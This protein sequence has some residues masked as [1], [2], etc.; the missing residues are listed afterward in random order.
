MCSL[1]SC[2]VLLVESPSGLLRLML[3][4]CTSDFAIA[5]ASL[6]LILETLASSCARWLFMLASV[7]SVRLGD[8]VAIGKGG[9]SVSS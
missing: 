3:G 9:D 7:S 6:V 8:A 4:T 2:A 1:S 5:S